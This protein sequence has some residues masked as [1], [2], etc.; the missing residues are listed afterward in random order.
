LFSV[1]KARKSDMEQIRQLICLLFP[2]ANARLMKRDRF[3]IAKKGQL[4]VGFCH[5]RIK[6]KKCYIAGLG[7]LSHY[8]EHGIGSQLMSEALYDADKKGVQECLI[9]VQALNHAAKIYLKM[10]FFEKRAGKTLV[11]VRKRPT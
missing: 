1:S 10:G 2:R 11:L 5:Y 9:K 8:R 4:P 6:N 7:V 3:L